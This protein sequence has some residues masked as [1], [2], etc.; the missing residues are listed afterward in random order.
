MSDP[1]Q[2]IRAQ[3]PGHRSDPY[4]K[5]AVD[6]LLRIVFAGENVENEL[7]NVETVIAFFLDDPPISLSFGAPSSQ[8][9]RLARKLEV[10][11]HQLRKG[12]D[13]LSGLAA[14][15]DQFNARNTHEEGASHAVRGQPDPHEAGAA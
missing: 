3:F 7:A 12:A 5:A 2:F 15:A 6:A 14:Y 1:A 13:T 8:C 4:Q 9:R 11:A 10:L